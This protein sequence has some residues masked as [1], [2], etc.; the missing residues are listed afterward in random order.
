MGLAVILALQMEPVDK[1]LFSTGQTQRPMVAGEV[2]G[3]G[4]D[5]KSMQE[6]RSSSK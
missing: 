6:R 2:K 3:M 5:N 4:E 1:I